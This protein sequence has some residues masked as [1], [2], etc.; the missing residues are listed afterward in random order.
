MDAVLNFL[1]GNF[2]IYFPKIIFWLAWAGAAYFYF[3]AKP[4]AIK[5][6]AIFLAVFRLLYA[7]FLAYGQRFIWSQNEFTNFFVEYQGGSYFSEYAWIH[8]GLNATLSIFSALLFWV[9]LRSLKSYQERFFHEGETE[10][11]LALALICGWPGILLFICFGLLMVV[12]VSVF[13]MI[14]AKEKYTTLGVPFLL[15][16][17]VVLWGSIALIDALELG[18]LKI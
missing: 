17:P 15:A 13:K 1:F 16:C 2:A 7:G 5:H 11:G 14:F 18:A 3:T 10:L 4:R 9:F 8:F 12:L 6:L